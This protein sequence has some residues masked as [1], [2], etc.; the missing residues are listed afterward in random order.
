MHRRDL[1]M[2]GAEDFTR[3]DLS[4]ISHHHR[5][6]RPHRSGR[7]HYHGASVGMPA[8]ISPND[9]KFVATDVRGQIHEMV[10]LS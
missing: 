5:R 7:A 10:E 6:R 8:I 3:A 4:E 2:A 9:R 1:R